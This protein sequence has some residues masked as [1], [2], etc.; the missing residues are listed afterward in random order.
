EETELDPGGDEEHRAWR[1]RREGA[2]RAASRPRHRA[3]S[4]TKLAHERVE[5]TPDALPPDLEIVETDVA[6]DGRPRGSRFGTLV[7]AV[8]SLAPFDARRDQL[9]AIAAGQALVLG[10]TEQERRAAVDAVAAAL[11]HGLMA[12]AA[13]SPDCRREVPLAVV[14]DDGQIAEG[15]ADLVF[16][17]GARWRV[18]DFKTDAELT[19]LRAYAAQ[20]ALYRR[21]IEEAT[22]DDVV[23]TLLRV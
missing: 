19:D 8:L 21:A 16:W 12:A 22:G 15:I 23:A 5:Q 6:R 9:D 20:L 1:E 2:I 10:A 13:T 17:E 4:I 18:V 3:S 7:H 14:L 11:R